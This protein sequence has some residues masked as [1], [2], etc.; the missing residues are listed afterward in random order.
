MGGKNETRNMEYGTG[1]GVTSM[2]MKQ[3]KLSKF[4]HTCTR[5]IVGV[6]R[7]YYVAMYDTGQN[8]DVMYAIHTISF[9]NKK[10]HSNFHQA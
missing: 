8:K 2:A 1:R 5:N 7:S 4:V 9:K 10:K 3:E 6:I